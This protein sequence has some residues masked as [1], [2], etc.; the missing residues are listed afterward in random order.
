[1]PAALFM[2]AVHALFRHLT[3]TESSPAATL[4]RLD[5][6]L[7]AANPSDKY[8][9]VALGLYD[10]RTGETTLAV[11][12]HPPPLLRRTDG[13]VEEIAVRPGLPLGYGEIT[14]RIA[15]HRLTLAPGETL[16]L[17]TDGFSE[18]RVPGGKAVFDRERLQE[19]LG[20]PRASLSLE[21]CAEAARAAVGQF[22]GHSEQQDDL[23]MLLLRRNSAT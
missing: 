2:V 15:E 9:T 5:A 7:A 22:I 16:I 19:V 13:R 21:A 1:M 23:T 14:S 11:A 8:V 18:A 4:A 3:L 17:Y 20:G 12:A 10:P 6:A